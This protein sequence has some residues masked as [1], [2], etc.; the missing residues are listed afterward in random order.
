MIVLI[1]LLI[2]LCLAAALLEYACLRDPHIPDNTISLVG[3]R[4]RIAAYSML[5]VRMSWMIA[6]M[7]PVVSPVSII[8]LLLLAGS[9]LIRCSNRLTMMTQ[10]KLVGEIFEPGKRA[11]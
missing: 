2:V 6:D 1:L 8:A 4:L 5:A 10:I 3:R 11:K 7:P 9:D